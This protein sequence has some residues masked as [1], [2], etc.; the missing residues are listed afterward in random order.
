MRFIARL[1]LAFWMAVVVLKHSVLPL[2]Y[3]GVFHSLSVHSAADSK[4]VA[5]FSDA[6]TGDRYRSHVDAEKVVELS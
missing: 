5:G 6:C 1:H 2:V 3:R 4:R